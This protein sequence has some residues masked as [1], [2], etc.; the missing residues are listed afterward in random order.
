MAKARNKKDFEQ[1]A[2]QVANNDYEKDT[3][4]LSGLSSWALGEVLELLAAKGIKA[5]INSKGKVTA[6]TR[7]SKITTSGAGTTA[8]IKTAGTLVNLKKD[9]DV[10]TAGSAVISN[11]A[12][13]VTGP[14]AI[15]GVGFTA[16]TAVATAVLAASGLTFGFDLG[17]S[18][19]S[20]LMGDDF[21]W[22]KDSVG[23]KIL[24]Y[25]SGDPNDGN[26]YIDVDL[27]DRIMQRAYNYGLFSD[28]T[29]TPVTNL[30]AP[31]KVIPYRT[32]LQLLRQKY[33][34]YGNIPE[35]VH[36]TDVLINSGESLPDNGLIIETRSDSVGTG[37]YASF[38][39]IND[40]GYKTLI[41][42]LYRFRNNVQICKSYD[43][44]GGISRYA[45]SVLSY[46]IETKT[47]TS[48]SNLSDPDN[49]SKNY[50]ITSEHVYD[51]SYGR[52]ISV[53]GDYFQC[54]LGTAPQ[55]IDGVSKEPGATYPSSSNTTVQSD[56][57]T[58]YD[59]RKYVTYPDDTKPSVPKTVVPI[60]IVYNPEPNENTPS[61]SDTQSTPTNPSDL[62]DLIMDTNPEVLDD[63]G[64]D[65]DVDLPPD[66]IGDTP[67]IPP[68]SS[69]RG[70]EDVGVVG[71]YNPSLLALNSFSGWLWSENFFD[72]L[73]KIFQSPSDAVISLSIVY[74]KPVLLRADQPI[75]TGY[76]TAKDSVGAAILSDIVNQYTEV[77]CGSLTINTRF[78]NILD[79]APYTKVQIYL[80]FIG[81]KELDTNDIMGATLSLKYSVDVVT[82]TCLAQISVSRGSMNA[83]LYKFAGNCSV[84]L[85]LSGGTYS[86]ILS[87]CISIATSVF[88][89]GSSALTGTAG[90]I[91]GSALSI[92]RSGSIGGNA[93]AMDSR[94]P[95][96][97]ITRPVRAEAE[98]YNNFY[99]FPSNNTVILGDCTGY[100]RVKNIILS[101]LNATDAELSEL[102]SILKEGVLI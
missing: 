74:A 26:T 100:T 50:V 73:E 58:W 81:I 91:T 13:A 87:N 102:E 89:G 24:T 78:N 101:G 54:N 3:F 85:P 39:Y 1:I 61:Q 23:G 35:W 17:Q 37:V 38:T 2:N 22:G 46:P 98:G 33:I 79:Y 30:R 47:I 65:P 42:E 25:F 4:D 11:S 72:N 49:P 60:K 68:I 31:W 32:F 43:S 84:Q 7:I 76:L 41:R 95:Y 80:P 45:L 5:I 77:D 8:A 69:L 83:V 9:A 90:L 55:T 75:V 48:Y 10:L 21:D 28:G 66:D 40:L 27:A 97:I 93:G 51:K 59:N 16:P 36:N 57:P 20:Q 67:V 96:L 14:G 94:T 88:T 52:I 15:A 19:V 29:V 34:N 99:G 44:G 70:I 63:A 6:L 18:V 64:I 71:I 53:D 12:G 82:G 86:S 92:E 56:Y 62:N